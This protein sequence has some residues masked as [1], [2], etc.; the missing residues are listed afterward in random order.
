MMSELHNYNT[1]HKK[2]NISIS[3][4]YDIQIGV[5]FT[6][7]KFDYIL[8]LFNTFAGPIET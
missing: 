8:P 4:T 2:Q 1:L 7:Q 3:G 6:L 5:L